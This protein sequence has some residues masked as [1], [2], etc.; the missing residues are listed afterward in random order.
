M[1]CPRCGA[2]AYIGNSYCISC[3]YNADTLKVKPE[4]YYKTNWLAVIGWLTVGVCLILCFFGFVL[5]G[6]YIN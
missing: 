2:S 5:L 1:N 4:S 3:G 6:N